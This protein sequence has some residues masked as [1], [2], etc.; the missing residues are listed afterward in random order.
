MAEVA[1]AMAPVA[2]L[3]TEEPAA[4]PPLTPMARAWKAAN[5]LGEDGSALT[6][7]TIPALQCEA[8]LEGDEYW[9]RRMHTYGCVLGLGAVE[10]ERI[11]I[12]HV[13]TELWDHCRAGR[14][15]KLKAGVDT[16][17]GRGL[18]GAW[19]A[20]GGLRDGLGGKKC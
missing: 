16:L 17:F 9:I 6:E 20:E 12:G 19:G 3:T 1:V 10:P 7:N 18:G 4:A 2:S 13:E 8:G 14:A 11:E 15:N 5:D